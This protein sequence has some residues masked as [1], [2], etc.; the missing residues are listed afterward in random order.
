M[1][2]S[3]YYDSHYIDSHKMM[4]NAII[5]ER[6]NGK[7]YHFKNKCI[8]YSLSIEDFGFVWIRQTEVQIHETKNKFFNDLKDLPKYQN[9]D[10]KVLGKE[11]L[12][13]KIIDE[14]LEKYDKW[15]KIGEFIALSTSL[16][17]KSSSFAK[18]KYIVFDEF[19]GESYL[20][21]EVNIFLNLLDTICRRRENVK[22][23]ML[24]NA[25]TTQNPYFQEFKIR[26]N[27]KT[28][29]RFTK[30]DIMIVEYCDSSEYREFSKTHGIGKIFA[31]LDY[32]NYSIDNKFILDDMTNV[33]KCPI[34]SKK[35]MF[36]LALEGKCYTCWLV[37]NVLFIGKFIECGGNIYSPYPLDV[38]DFNAIM[39]TK[40][41][42][43]GLY[44]QRKFLQ[45]CIF[46][47]N[48]EIK[49]SVILC[50]QKLIGNF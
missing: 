6:G 49:N 25:L 22:V 2:K 33:C 15:L 7:T 48:L 45:N 32:G 40:Q 14:E 39:I 5:G 9:W 41:T 43:Q 18:V 1:T 29:K 23:Y 4:L 26:V 31:K 38:K 42:N 3:M 46:Y 30:N 28:M 47:E 24:S 44:L 37:N 13:R 21:N 12:A 10:F 17:L 36:H 50:M 8:D 20:S 34:G 19:L 11:I 27:P 16:N 35:F